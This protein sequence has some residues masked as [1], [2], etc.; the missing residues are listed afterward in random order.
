MHKTKFAISRMPSADH[1]AERQI[2]HFQ[3]LPVDDAVAHGGDKADD[4]QQQK[5][6][7]D[8]S[9]RAVEREH[10]GEDADARSDV[11]LVDHA[12]I[13]GV[14]HA[15]RLSRVAGIDRRHHVALGG[16]VAEKRVVLHGV[17]LAQLAVDIDLHVH[18]AEPQ[19]RDVP[20]RRFGQRGLQRDVG[21]GV[22]GNRERHARAVLRH[23]HPPV[24]KL[25]AEK[26]AA[27]HVRG[28]QK[29]PEQHVSENQRDND[30]KSRSDVFH[31]APRKPPA[32]I[33]TVFC[34][35]K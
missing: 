5:R 35:I 13:V 29:F 24:G 16:A 12:G 21:V 14:M 32:M 15:Q 3:I 27:R 18:A 26:A 28:Q 34:S 4:R 19:R 33:S 17:S 31:R 30:N 6:E 7:A 11:D 2:L 22:S 20:I 8:E 1:H 10:V 23:A 25:L 9:L